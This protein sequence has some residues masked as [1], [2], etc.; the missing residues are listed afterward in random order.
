MKNFFSLS[1]MY[2]LDMLL[3]LVTIP[4][5]IRHIGLDK[6]GLLNFAAA[7]IAYFGIIV[8]Y[9]FN[10]TATK[11][12][13]VNSD[14]PKELARIFNSVTTSKIVLILISAV[15]LCILLLAVPKFRAY[16]SLYLVIFAG[17]CFQNLLPVWF[18]QGMQNLKGITIQNSI[19][20]LFF[21]LLI[22]LLVK[23]EADYWIVP[24]LTGLGFLF[25]FLFSYLHAYRT[26]RLRYVISSLQAVKQQLR[27]GLY[28][29]LSQVKISFFSSFNIIVL[30]FIAGNTAVAYFS[31]ADK[32]IRALAIIQVPV[33]ASLY[34]YFSNLL[35]NNKLAA[36]RNVNRI[37]LLGSI[38]YVPVI[39]LIFI[40]SHDVVYFIFGSGM[41]SAE[42][43]V[44]ILSL[45]PLFI[46]LNNLSGTQML[47]NMGK[48]KVFFNVLLSTAVLNVLLVVP[49]TYK[50]SF[51][52]TAV[53]V[54]ISELYLCV[55]MY[56]AFMLAKRKF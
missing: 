15:I 18:F 11:E 56:G 10:L 54:F 39:V 47:L 42:K 20:K 51:Y 55:V 1:V 25:A 19:I 46:F 16:Y 12:V 37:A 32:V 49:L 36:Y 21:T 50:Y 9:G 28:V 7:T 29:F 43:I 53:S 2:G 22:F 35:K 27:S 31:S 13:A 45:L 17:V 34:P 8:N 23:K 48:D 44:R 4:Y 24:I 3:P 33:V 26:Y 40:F 41:E 14:N 5:L 38:L 6:V 30:G 52:G